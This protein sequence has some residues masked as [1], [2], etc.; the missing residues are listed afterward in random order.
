MLLKIFTLAFD[1]EIEGF[2]D[3]IISEFCLNKK[4]LRLET[5]FF[6]KDG[7]PYWSVAIHYELVLAATD[8][9]RELD[10]GQKLLFQKLKE[11][12]KESSAKEGIPAYLVAT[13]AQFVQMIRLKCRALESFKNVRGFG[14]Q[15]TQKYGKRIV[16]LIKGFYEDNKNKT[17]Q[18]KSADQP[19]PSQEEEPLPFE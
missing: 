11:W 15:R 18:D 10:D 12:R 16:E 9:L 6:N 7:R 14:K 5:E 4:V 8:K 17:T 1:E 19:L 2:P 3:E 13:D